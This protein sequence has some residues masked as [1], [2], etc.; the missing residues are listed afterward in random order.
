M[1][2]GDQRRILLSLVTAGAMG[3]WGATAHA[4]AVASS[5]KKESRRGANFWNAQAAIDGDLETCWQVPGES[6]NVGEHIMLDVPKS[7]L[8]K[9]GMVVG[10]AK[11]DSTWADYARVK[12]VKIEIFGYNESNEL[13]PGGKATASFEDKQGMQVVDVEDMQIGADLF[14]G[15]V[16]ITIT[17]FYEGLDYPNLAVSEVLLYLKESLEAAPTILDISTTDDGHPQESMIDDNAKSFWAGAA[18]DAKVSFEASGYAVSSVGLQA[19]PKDYARP[20]KVSLSVGGKTLT[21]E[22]ENNDEVQWLLVPTTVGYT[23]SGWG[24]I[25]LKVLETYPGSKNEQLAIAELDLRATA[26]EGL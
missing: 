17:E 13:V 12:T 6:S 2:A 10:W 8:D 1:A 16:K 3:F 24:T 21:H 18:A 14:G 9:L 15:K 4:G 19:G 5:F 22:L 11:D 20:K 25:E 7:E 23:G 26:Y